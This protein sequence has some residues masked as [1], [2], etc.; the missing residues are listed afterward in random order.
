MPLPSTRSVASATYPSLGPAGVKRTPLEKGFLRIEAGSE[1]ED[2]EEVVAVGVADAAKV[3]AKEIVRAGPKSPGGGA[4]HE[5]DGSMGSGLGG[6]PVLRMRKLEVPPPRQAHSP[7]SAS[8]RRRAWLGTG[9]AAGGS[10][11][12]H[13]R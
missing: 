3:G 4:V 7:W 9:T 2:V 8:R 11:H 10:W 1:V 6:M 5:E 12:W 13:Y